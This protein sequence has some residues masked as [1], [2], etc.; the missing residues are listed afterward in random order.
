MCGPLLSLP[1]FT[2]R[3]ANF[4]VHMAHMI[5]CQKNSKE[6][7]GVMCLLQGGRGGEWLSIRLVNYVRARKGSTLFMKFVRKV[8][9]L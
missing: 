8:S 7:M 2:C 6:G 3:S 9:F 4:K 1:V 5:L